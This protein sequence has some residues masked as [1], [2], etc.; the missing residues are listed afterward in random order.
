[1][2]WCPQQMAEACVTGLDLPGMQEQGAVPGT[3]LMC[4]DCTACCP[5]LLHEMARSIVLQAPNIH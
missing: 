5:D 4:A 3:R 1:M 2:R